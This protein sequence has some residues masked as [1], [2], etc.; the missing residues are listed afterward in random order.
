VGPSDGTQREAPSTAYYLCN[1]ILVYWTLTELARNIA[2]L[3]AAARLRTY[4]DAVVV[5]TGGAPGIV[6]ISCEGTFQKKARAMVLVDHQIVLTEE[7]SQGRHNIDT[8]AKVYQV[9]V[10]DFAEVQR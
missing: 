3:D 7:V 4:K 2:T 6:P 9:D 1:E 5:I 8:D 10:R